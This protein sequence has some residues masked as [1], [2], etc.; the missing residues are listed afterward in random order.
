M[1]VRA[2]TKKYT[3][4]RLADNIFSGL[5]SIGGFFESLMHIGAILVAFFQERLFKGSFLKQLYQVSKDVTLTNNVDEKKMVRTVSKVQRID[6]NYIKS[7]LDFIVLKRERFSYG[8]R[9]IVDYITRC[10]CLSKPSTLL[11]RE[12]ISHFLYKKGNEKLK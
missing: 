12:N 6:V 9:A 10:M 1:R 4:M 2:G 8:P 5:E 7:L 11:K 3:Y